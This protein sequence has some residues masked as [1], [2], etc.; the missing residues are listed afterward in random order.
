M[1]EDMEAHPGAMEAHPGAMEAH[2][3]AMEV[4]TVDVE[5]PPTAMKAHCG[6]WVG[7]SCYQLMLFTLGDSEMYLLFPK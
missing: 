1:H 4:Q 2:P 7:A 3:G 6:L 5:V